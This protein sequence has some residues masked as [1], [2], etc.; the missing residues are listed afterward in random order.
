[1]KKGYYK[2]VE[3]IIHHDAV[4]AVE[5]VSHYHVITEYPNGGRDVEKVID[6]PG[7]TAKDAWD[8]VTYEDEFVPFTEK[9]LA[10]Y[11]IE[12]LVCLLASSDYKAIKYAEGELT[13][14]EYAPIREL[15][16][17]Y[18]AEINQLEEKIKD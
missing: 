11:R 3:K 1:M 14:E 5:E 8:E 10:Q 7:T 2:K 6:V 13:E 18:R 4:E 16:R 15:R 17:S 9:E 12:E